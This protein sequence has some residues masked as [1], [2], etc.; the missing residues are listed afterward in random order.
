M[1][2]LSRLGS[3][4]SNKAW[5]LCMV[6]LTV[7][8]I[9]LLYFY[10]LSAAEKTSAIPAYIGSASCRSCHEKFYQLWAPSHHG[11]AMQ[12]YTEVFAKKNLTPQDEEITIES[13]RYQAMI[14]KGAG[15]VMETGPDGQKKYP[16][17]HVLGGKYVY[18]FLTELER[19]YLQV[20]PVAFDI[21]RQKWYDTAASG[22]RHFPGRD[23]DEPFNW[24]DRPYTFN[25]S[26]YGCHV[27]QLVKNYDSQTDTYNTHWKE[28]GINCET[29]HGPAA[30]H[31]KIC[32]EAEAQ[33]KKPK[34]MK[35]E[36]I[37][38][39]RGYTAHQ[40]NT[41]CLTC[42]SKAVPI[43]SEFVPGEDFF[44]HYDLVTLE[45]PDYYPDGRDLGENYTCT[46]WM[47]SPCVNAGQLDCM[48]CHTSSG[49]YRFKG[50]TA[51][52]ACVKCHTDK[53]DI[54]THSHHDTDSGVTEC[55]QCHMPKT[56]FG[57]MIRSVAQCMQ[58]VSS[59]SESGMGG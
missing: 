14:N 12:P 3:R 7:L 38:Q 17:L 35:L 40:V 33:G 21:R 45:H 52:D 56:E 36:T 26:C 1:S 11:L 46:S 34:E 37:T 15:F 41:A 2:R 6:I 42:H 10:V 31:V 50:Q 55:I 53:R 43:T 32:L 39:D 8:G 48:Y 9:V 4:G 30:E 13:C 54:A 59:G 5:A 57:R 28:P 49:R 20:L 58:S 18:Y 19:G 44:Q 47:L 29:C 24:K 22:V 25:S 51:N 27:S 23:E 16:M